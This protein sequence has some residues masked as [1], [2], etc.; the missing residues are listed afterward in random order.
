[1]KKQNFLNQKL[2]FFQN[3]A[4]YKKAERVPIDPELYDGGRGYEFQ[5]ILNF[6]NLPKNAKIIELGAGYGK[7][8]LP[9]LFLGFKVTAVDIGEKLLRAI[10]KAAKKNKLDKNLHTIQSDFRKSLIM[11]EYDVALCISTF[12]LLADT[13]N[14][15][16]LIFS[17]LVKSVK[18]GGSVVVVEPNPL[19]PFLYILYFFTNQA[20]WNVEKY[21]LKSTV[22]NLKKIFKGCKLSDIKISYIGFL[23]LRYIELPGV[24]LIN[25]IVNNTPLLNMFSSFIYIRGRR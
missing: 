19:N 20:S 11:S 22:W 16:Q 12:H 14:E 8:V 9:L 6:A 10:I 1:M 5:K 13:E 25:N 23:P 21:F 24:G 2:A 17:N 4:Y 7:Y 18:P 3:K 15:R